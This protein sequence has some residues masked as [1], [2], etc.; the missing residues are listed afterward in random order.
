MG[1]STEKMQASFRLL[2]LITTP[3]LAEKALLNLTPAPADRLCR[4]GRGALRL[5]PIPFDCSPLEI[6][7]ADKPVHVDRDEVRLELSDAH[8]LRRRSVRRI[9]CEKQKDIERCLRYPELAAQRLARRI[10]CG[11]E[12]S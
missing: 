12:L 9:V 2:M 7:V 11:A 1:M 6:S 8:D 3:K 10:V 5:P 4:F